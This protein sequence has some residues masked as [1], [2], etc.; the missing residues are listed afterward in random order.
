MNIAS[1]E[2]LK[3]TYG[4]KTLF[5]DIS[6]SIADT[7]KIGV[8]GVNGSGKTS[9]LKIIGSLD[10]PDAG[11]V[12]FFGTKRV[13][14]LPQDPD[15]NPDTTVLSQVFCANSPEMNL[16]RDYES[17]LAAL[18][19]SPEDAP[20][21][22]RLLSLSQR[23]DDENLWNLKSQVETILSQ[24]GIHDYHKKIKQLSG[25]QRKRVAMASALL[26]PCDLLILDEPTNHLDNDTIAWL[27]NYLLN[28]KGALLMVTHDRYFLD[29][30]VTRTIELDKGQ[31]YEYTGNYSDFLE[32]KANRREA[33]N[34]IEAKRQNL[35]RR[36]LAWIRRGARA[37]TTKQKARIQRFE[38]IKDQATDLSENQMEISVGFS[39]LGKKVIEIEHLCKSFGPQKIIA[40]FSMILGPSERIGII[41]KNGYGKSTLLNLLAGKLKPDSGTITLG[42]TVKLGYFSQESEDMDLSLRAI[43]YIREKAEVMENSRGE[44]VTAAQMMELFLFDKNSQWVYISELSG[45]E[46]RRLYLLGILMMAP[47]VLLFDEPTND[48]DIDTLTILEAYL[49]EFQGSVLTVSHDRYFLDRTCEQILSFDGKGQITSQTGNYSDYIKKH[50]LTGLGTK[51][52][53]PEQPEK[54]TAAPASEKPK[55]RKPG[56]TYKEKREQEALLLDLEAKDQRLDFVTQKLSETTRD[57]TV[58]E[59]LA[60]E[61][62]VLEDE[63]LAIMDRLETLETLEK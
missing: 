57:Y 27:E 30:V 2:N 63:L 25:G 6:F 58:L 23:I 7:D 40:D 37:R 43:D 62:A 55:T 48:L 24:L 49:D 15:L 29:R 36:E 33:Q 45:G 16:V 61:K 14:I 31:L 54:K 47:N 28:R 44:T 39:R 5:H 60:N 12:K 22:K 19:D 42:D 32:Q 3:K 52:N 34:A 35:Y 13:E 38:E 59:E 26:T 18:E 8:I 17:T 4:V 21:Q 46:R 9:L 56:L 1:I 50:P 41:G 51:D 53:S 11:A 10:S 20:L